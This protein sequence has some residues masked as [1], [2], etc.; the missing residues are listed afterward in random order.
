MLGAAF[1]CLQRRVLLLGPLT[2]LPDLSAATGR[3][4]AERQ[5]PPLDNDG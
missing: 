4:E 1:G 3:K 2:K 5:L